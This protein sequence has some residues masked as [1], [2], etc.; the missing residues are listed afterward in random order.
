M[1]LSI[2]TKFFVAAVLCVNSGIDV[3]AKPPHLPV[4]EQGGST[5][6]AKLQDTLKIAEA[7]S[8]NMVLQRE[9]PVTIWGRAAAGQTIMVQFAGQQKTTV[10]DVAGKWEVVLAPLQASSTP[11][12]LTVQST[13]TLTLKN[14]L[15]GDV[16]LCSGQSNMEYPLDRKLKKYTA[17][18]KGIDEAEQELTTPK[19]DGI[20]YL[21]VEKNLNKIPVLPTKG[22][23]DGNDTL[24]RYISAIGYF[25]AKDIYE[26]T[27]VPIGIISSS[28]GGTRIEQWQ[29][30][31]SYAQSEIFKDSAITPNFKIDGMHPGQMYR[32][33]IEPLIPFT[34]KGVL[35]YQGESN[36]M[37]EDQKTYPAKFELFVNTWRKLFKDNDLPFYYVQV[38]P[39]LYTSRKDAKK[40]SAT[41][42]PEFWEAQT[43]CLSIKNTGMVVT[44]DLVD[45]LSN[46]HPSYKWTVGR[47]LALWALEKDY[48][49]EQKEISGPV[50]AGMRKNRESIFISFSHHGTKLMSNNGSDTLSCFEIA[51]RDGK[52]VP[53]KATTDGD[54]VIV[55]ADGLKKPK[56]VRFAW[57]ETAQ[58]NLVNSEGLPAVPFRTDRFDE[59][60]FLSK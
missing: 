54:I 15:V 32:G 37:V 16:W 7:F 58:P 47:R 22:W 41:L 25:F 51:G 59:E 23:T 55:Y 52:F 9:K 45:E 42:L 56:Y 38:A 14:I 19:P 43:K 11:Q 34:I 12:N 48:H 18:K 31:W 3:L 24:V 10:A 35:W 36:A 46:I 27:K 29:P 2:L 26:K 8:D 44:T 5:S 17:P 13:S 20:R 21:Y 1:N 4:L 6:F 40:H 60:Y 33:L 50:Y 57:N 49:I 53:A 28:W 39:H 30:D